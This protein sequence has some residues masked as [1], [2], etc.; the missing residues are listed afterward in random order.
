MCTLCRSR[1]E[2]ASG[3]EGALDGVVVIG[4]TVADCAEGRNVENRRQVTA[5]LCV[6][7]LPLVLLNHQTQTE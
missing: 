6:G 4:L 3:I 7:E 5:G 1:A 2:L